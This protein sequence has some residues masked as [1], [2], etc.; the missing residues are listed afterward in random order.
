MVVFLSEESNDRGAKGAQI[1]VQIP[2]K[3]KMAADSVV[4]VCEKGGVCFVCVSCVYN[5]CPP[6]FFCGSS[7]ASVL[8]FLP[9]PT[10][11]ES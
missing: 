10:Y 5:L 6:Y 1:K 4:C 2:K 8:L 9:I 3:V 7:L 11:V